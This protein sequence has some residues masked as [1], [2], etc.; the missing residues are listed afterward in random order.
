MTGLSGLE[1]LV[2]EHTLLM[3][4]GSYGCTLSDVDELISLTLRLGTR[5]YL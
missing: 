1:G 5:A 3:D 4:F 2:Y